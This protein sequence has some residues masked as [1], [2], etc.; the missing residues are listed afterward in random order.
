MTDAR[1]RRA[2]PAML[3]AAAALAT[4]VL[5]ACV[6][7]NSARG[8]VDRFIE[9]YYI[10]IDLKAAAPLCTG[11]ALDK[12]HQELALTAG[13]KIDEST[14]KPLIHYKLKQERGS[15]DHT[16]FLFAA[17]IDVPDGGSFDKKWMIAA[18]KEG[19]DWKISNFS[20]YE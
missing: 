6:P 11:L 10:A 8:V 12:I 9:A 16:M 20:E 17:T 13:Q 4:A 2:A 18:R 7:P 15:P 3:A 5:A 19:K 14:R 1:P